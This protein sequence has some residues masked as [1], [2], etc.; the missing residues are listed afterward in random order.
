MVYEQNKYKVDITGATQVYGGCNDR[1]YFVNNLL[2][3]FLFQINFT[4]Q[5][6]FMLRQLMIVMLW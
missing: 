1:R 6:I 5:R 3:T 2:I 4:V